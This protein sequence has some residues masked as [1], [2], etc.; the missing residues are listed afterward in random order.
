[1]KAIVRKRQRRRLVETGKEELVFEIRGIVVESDKID[2]WMKRNGITENILYS[3]SL[4]ASTP[5]AL[6]T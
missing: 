2:R 3:S 4:T 6:N 5:A 1:M